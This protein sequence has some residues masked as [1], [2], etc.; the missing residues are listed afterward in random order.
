MLSSWVADTPA[1]RNSL[2][3]RDF[4]QL[5]QPY[6][7]LPKLCRSTL[8]LPSSKNP[9]SSLFRN[10]QTSH[11]TRCGAQPSRYRNVRFGRDNYFLADCIEAMFLAICSTF[12][13]AV[14][15]CST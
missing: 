7:F 6:R 12:A 11:I 8:P 9:S 13:W 15:D 14:G 3:N 5:F 10:S 2:E 1:L 4:P